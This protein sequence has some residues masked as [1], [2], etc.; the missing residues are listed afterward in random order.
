MG[1]RWK[2]AHR[3]DAEIGKE[4]CGLRLE[5]GVPSVIHLGRGKGRAGQLSNR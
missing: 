2:D 3:V 4:Y 1:E 5:W